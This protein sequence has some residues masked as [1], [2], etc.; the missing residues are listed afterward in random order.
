MGSEWKLRVEDIIDCISKIQSYT[1]NMDYY[2]FSKDPKTVDAVV[3]NFEIIGEAAGH[4]PEEVQA[5]YPDLA[6]LEMRGMRNLMI[7]AYFRVSL[8]ILWQTIQFDLKPLEEGMRRI[9][10]EAD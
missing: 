2:A 9:L 6:W 10:S 5:R 7:H 4:I 3:R 8:P 1:A